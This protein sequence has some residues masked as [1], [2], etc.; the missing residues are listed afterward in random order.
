MSYYNGEHSLIIGDKH[1]WEDWH[2][3]P[4]SRPGVSMPQIRTK[5]IE[6]PGAFGTLDLTELLTGCPVFG[7]R[8]G[9]WEF[10]MDPDRTDK[11]NWANLY[12]T[13][14][15]YIH[16]RRHTVILTDDPEYY[17]QG[18]LAVGGL[19]PGE[20]FTS[21]TINYQLEPYK[22]PVHDPFSDWLWD[23]FDFETGV[24]GDGNTTTV[25]G[26][27]TITVTGMDDE[28][29]PAIKVSAPMTLTFDGRNYSLITGVNYVH[30]IVIGPG[31]HTLT[32]TGNGTV[33]ISKM[34][35]RL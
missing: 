8:S 17:Y 26:S 31:N 13:I 20:A 19:Q 28:F 7:D 18:R 23:P 33:A 10:I 15:M 24:I 22:L 12:Q 6:I 2:L 4:S 25:S 11:M 21:I 16:G 9:S 5:F 27:A 1:T 29:S 14:A 34:G 32:F 3:I 35:A 30:E